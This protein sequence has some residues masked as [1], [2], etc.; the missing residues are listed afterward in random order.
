MPRN[1]RDQ[2]V[3]PSIGCLLEEEIAG[4]LAK[5]EREVDRR[6]FGDHMKECG[7]C[8]EAVIDHANETV[9]IPI[10]RQLANEKGISFDEM[11]DAFVEEIRKKEQEG[12]LDSK[13]GKKGSK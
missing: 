4:E 9:T 6:R 7:K 5:P 13:Y 3:D 2:C 1:E 11:L 10:L 12:K 8:R